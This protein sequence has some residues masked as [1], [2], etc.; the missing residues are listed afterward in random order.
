M[1]REGLREV[2][3]SCSLQQVEGVVSSRLR[4]PDGVISVLGA[5]RDVKPGLRQRRR[6]DR[7]RASLIPPEQHLTA[8]T[9]PPRIRAR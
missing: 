9:G 6:R 3:P 1:R 4:A 8:R 7:H 2:C 5:D